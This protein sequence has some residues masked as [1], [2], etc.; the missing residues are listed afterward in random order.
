VGG[1]R[2]ERDGEQCLTRIFNLLAR[3]RKVPGGPQRKK[4][5]R[6]SLQGKGTL[7]I[8]GIGAGCGLRWHHGGKRAKMIIAANSGQTS[9]NDQ[10]REVGLLL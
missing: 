4:K 1:G 6:A 5:E 2:G 7:H 3:G 8:F 10:E 9:K